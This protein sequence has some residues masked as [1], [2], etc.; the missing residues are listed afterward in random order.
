MIIAT[1]NTAYNFDY[2]VELKCVCGRIIATF[3]ADSGYKTPITIFA[4]DDAREA[5][6]VF[7]AILSAIAKGKELYDIAEE[8]D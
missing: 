1:E 8:T 7:D 4:S 3:S 6:D 5:E 2:I